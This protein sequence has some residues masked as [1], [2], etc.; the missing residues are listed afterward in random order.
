VRARGCVEPA[1]ECVH[2]KI[3]RE[4]VSGRVKVGALNSEALG[5]KVVWMVRM[6]GG[7]VV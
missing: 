1:R 5:R 4:A 3:A 7:S 2:G 6:G